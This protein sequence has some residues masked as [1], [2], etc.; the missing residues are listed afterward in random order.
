MAQFEWADVLVFTSL[1]DTSGNVV[2][3]AFG[4]GTPVVCL[5]HQGVHDM[6]TERCGIKVPVT[7]PA[8]VVAGLRNAIVALEGDRELLQRLSE[9]AVE[10]AREFLWPAMGDRMARIYHQV[11]GKG[12]DSAIGTGVSTAPPPTRTD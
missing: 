3:E 11:L 4:H 9:G 1:R 5:D 2:L 10:R 8:E 12:D 7:T 6:V